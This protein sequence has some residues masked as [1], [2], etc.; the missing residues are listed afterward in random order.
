ML[1]NAILL[2]LDFKKELESDKMSRV[3]VLDEF[4]SG[5]ATPWHD[6][7]LASHGDLWREH[8]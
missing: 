2:W 7:V 6:M 3:G 8:V 4:K 5:L 1:H